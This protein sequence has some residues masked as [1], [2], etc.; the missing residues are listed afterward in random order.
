MKTTPK[1][2]QIKTIIDAE[3]MCE[4]IIRATLLFSRVENL[5]I[6]QIEVPTIANINGM[7]KNSIVA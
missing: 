3:I 4:I 7:A 2:S 5:M 6:Y 1:Y